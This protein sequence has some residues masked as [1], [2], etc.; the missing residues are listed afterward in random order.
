M[1]WIIV[2]IMIIVGIFILIKIK[3]LADTKQHIFFVL[4]VSLA[5]FLICSLTFVWLKSGISLKSYQGFIGLGKTYFS[6]LGGVFGNLGKITGNVI[7][8]N[9]GVNSTISP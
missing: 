5:I 9:W 3:R 2:T 8:Q 1:N 4:L 6:W 7:N